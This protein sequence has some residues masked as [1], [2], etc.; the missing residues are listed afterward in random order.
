M[1]RSK[2][3][4]YLINHEWSMIMKPILLISTTLMVLNLI[5]CL[6]GLPRTDMGL[7]TQPVPLRFEQLLLAGGVPYVHLFALASGL[8]VIAVGWYRM[9]V[10]TG[11]IYRLFRL[12]IGIRLVFS[13]RILAGTA[14][15][16]F[17]QAAQLLSAVLA[18]F[19]VYRS[20]QRIE[21]LD[22]GLYLAFRRSAWLRLLLPMHLPDATLVILIGL[23]LICIVLT[24]IHCVQRTSGRY[25]SAA[26][27]I[28][29]VVVSGLAVQFGYN[30]LDSYRTTAGQLLCQLPL[31]LCIAFII[32]LN[33]R[34]LQRREF[35]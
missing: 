32:F 15:L 33:Q 6:I 9:F 28:G 16:L 2:Q 19:L 11:S 10:P 25:L 35:A 18:Y 5:L 29:L 21:I 27:C 23:I 14:A 4:Y 31:L 8:T 34:W 17:I 30:G 12:P 22:Q 1:S 20:N 13:V 7:Q 26:I 24:V 3:L